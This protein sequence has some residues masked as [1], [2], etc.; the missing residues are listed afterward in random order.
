[1]Y[2]EIDHK[3]VPRKI[4]DINDS[5]SLPTEEPKIVLDKEEKNEDISGDHQFEFHRNRFH[6]TISDETRRMNVNKERIEKGDFY[7]ALMFFMKQ[8][9]GE[10]SSRKLQS[11]EGSSLS[12]YE[13]VVG[14]KSEDFYFD[15]DWGFFS[16]ILA[17]YNNH[18]VL[19]TSPDDWWNVIV[20]NVAAAI[21]ENAEKPS[22]RKYF[23]EHEGKELIEIKLPGRLDQVNY[24]WLFDQFSDEIRKRIKTPEYV[25]TM[26]ADFSTTT[27]DQ[28]IATEIMLM[29]SL[30]KYFDYG[31]CTT[32][33][34]I[35]GV[36]MKGTLSDWESLV[37]KTEN[38]MT[39]LE[40]I[41][42]DLSPDD[43]GF[44]RSGSDLKYWF[45]STL[46]ILNKLLDTY[47]GNPDKEWWSHILSWNRSGY[48][49]GS[50]S[51]WDGWIIDF[52][53]KCA[54][55]VSSPR[56]FKSG[57]TTV[58]LKIRDEIYG[59]PVSDTAE[60][61][62]GIFGFSVEEGDQ[63]PVVEAKQG[64]MLLLPKGSPVIARMKGL[65]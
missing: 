43:Q 16:T 13:N 3:L 12:D 51:W 36:D 25:N 33:C 15:Y 19:R 49:S 29:S 30:Q 20:R 60:L 55:E 65:D 44:R 31:M 7:S 57:I 41:L 26:K 50:R 24:S 22:V 6:R 42:N 27:S 35:P 59:P 28:L 53:G 9:E 37:A 10:G 21:D 45:Q 38:L 18:W 52:L 11:S 14:S 5:A 46:S 1:M 62:A 17:C 61:V 48:G 47:K 58:P 54:Q 39:M 8:K 2:I 23:V 56:N 64:W 63:A 40:P 4:S 32:L 34:G